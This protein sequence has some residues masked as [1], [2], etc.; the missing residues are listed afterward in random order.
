MYSTC[1]LLVGGFIGPTKLSPHLAKARVL[2][3]GRKGIQSN[4][5]GTLDP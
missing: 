3:I 1:V 5:F 2:N 4:M